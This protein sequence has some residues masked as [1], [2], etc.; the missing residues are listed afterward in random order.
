MPGHGYWFS[1]ARPVGGKRPRGR[2]LNEENEGY[3]DDDL[4]QDSSSIGLKKFV[5]DSHG[6]AADHG[7]PEV[8]D[9]A[10]NDDHERVDDVGLAQVGVDVGQLAE[11]DT[12]HAGNSRAQ[13]KGQRVNPLAANAHRFGHGSILRNSPDFETQAGTLQHDEKS[14]EDKHRE[15]DDIEPVVGD[16]ERLVQLER[17]AHPGGRQNRSVQ[18]GK[19]R[20]HE[21]LQ[22][23]ADA[24][25]R[26]Q[27]LEGPPVEKTN[28]GA[29]DQDAH[30]RRNDECRRNR[31]EDGGLA[32]IGHRHLNHI[33]R[34][35][36]EHH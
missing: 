16:R 14:H 20:A 1:D 34:I 28:D 10:E 6:H 19:D 32:V 2:A 7:A 12:G 18:R 25:R 13:P 5:D 30:Q 29:L 33:G 31:H 24:K 27:R 9:A 36:P 22:D 23:E 21:L 17:A 8:A 26:E 15:D 11:R 4:C 3:E 35:R